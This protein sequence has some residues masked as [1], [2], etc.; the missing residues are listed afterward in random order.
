MANLLTRLRWTAFTAWHLR[1]ESALP[2]WPL[3]RVQAIQNRRVRD[4]L[5]FAWRE[6]PF[7]R[8]AMAHAR[9]RPEDIRTADDLALLPLVG[10][11]ELEANPAQFSPAGRTLS[12]LTLQSSGTSGRSRNIDYDAAALFWS[13]VNGQR[14]RAALT[15]IVGQWTG[16][17]EAV[18]ARPGGLPFQ[19]RTFYES[20][21]WL[22]LRWEL[23]RLTISAAETFPQILTRLE[24]FRPDVVWGYGAH[25]G[26]YYRWVS[27]QGTGSCM[28]KA[29]IYG[30][31][32]MADADRSLIEEHLG[33][34][35]FSFYQA[36]EALRIAFQCEQRQGLHV[37]VD[38]IAVRAID[39]AG[40]RVGPGGSGEIVISNLV[41][42][43]TVLL[44][45]R[46]GDTV[47]LG[48]GPCPCGR[49]LPT[50][51]RVEGRADDLLLLPDG[52]SVHALGLLNGLQ[53]VPGVVQ[54][55][56][57]QE[58]LRRFRLL[59]VWQDGA[60]STDGEVSLRSSLVARFGLDATFSIERVQLIP[61]DAGGK[62]RAAISRCR[63]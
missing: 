7:Y 50:L 25:L 42:R 23:R 52:S 29:V 32:R 47:T 57:V 46:L 35:V 8:D 58:E 37:S 18:I 27:R 43:A 53:A 39:S 12:G 28:P 49:S 38:Q 13:L 41:N 14:Q 45:Y 59:V 9:L 62:V 17:R 30:G 51:A 5:G 4:M 56:L 22:P 16:Y 3:A 20:H 55:Q 36:A 24:E 21:A 19:I 61:T 11:A 60:A 44:N 10:K 26:A 48:N 31:D 63:G 1:R 6:V 34:A 54:V 33:V 15:K 40:R 2:F